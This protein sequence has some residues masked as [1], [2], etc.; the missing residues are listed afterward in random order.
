LSGFRD[1][2]RRHVTDLT[3]VIAEQGGT[4]PAEADLSGFVLAGFTAVAANAGRPGTLTVMQSNEVVT[5]DAYERALSSGMPTDLRPL[6]E[7]NREDERRHLAS[8]RT[9]LESLPGGEM[10]ST[11]GQ[12]QGW[13]TATWMNTLRRELPLALAVGVGA[14]AL[15]AGLML[16]PG[17]NQGEQTRVTARPQSEGERSRVV[18]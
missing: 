12:M 9:M 13:A 16:R 8:I 2:H 5:N 6:I 10:M 3:R 17:R 14:A 4:A 15:A 18:H 11:A 7:R 1:D